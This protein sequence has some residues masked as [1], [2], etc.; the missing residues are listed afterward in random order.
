ME[1]K[2]KNGEFCL[3]EDEFN[4]LMNNLCIEDE[5]PSILNEEKKNYVE[6]RT[7]YWLDNIDEIAD[8]HDIPMCG[9][10]SVEFWGEPCNLPEY[11]DGDSEEAIA[12]AKE[13][14][15]DDWFDIQKIT[16]DVFDQ[17]YGTT[18]F[19]DYCIVD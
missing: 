12:L 9:G 18:V 13:R 6:T 14:A 3:T 1:S 7:E 10:E 2:E 5:P 8:G 16:L 11:Y 4:F 15:E 19:P 17:E